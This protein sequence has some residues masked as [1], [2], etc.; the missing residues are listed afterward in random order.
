M[1]KPLRFPVPA[2][3]AIVILLGVACSSGGTTDQASEPPPQGS[4]A[5]LKS[6][7]TPLNLLFAQSELTTGKAILTFGLAN[8][9]GQFAT[10][11]T[12]G[13]WVAKDDR[14]PALGPFQSTFYDF[15]AGEKFPNEAPR[16]ELPGFFAA[17][18][19]IPEP[20]NWVVAAIAN[21]GSSRLVGMGTMKVVAEPAA[22]AIGTEAISAPTPVA[23]TDAERGKVCTRAPPD[24]MHL[25][26]LEEALRNGKPTVVTFSTP[27][28]CESRM[29]GPVVD[30]TLAVY[31]KVGAKKANFIHVEIYPEHD[32][33]KPA[34]AF[35]KWGF[36]SEPWTIVIDKDGVI[37][38]GFEGPLAAPLIEAELQPLL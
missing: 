9:Q 16:T 18:V 17:Q 4:I 26:S 13:V 6:G 31:E 32:Q 30:E 25:I 22:A 20:G 38:A 24:P 28:L 14:S 8:Q 5:A 19:D 7:G 10:G 29:C 37:K 27:A 21:T 1:S 12:P 33:S 36:Q 15:S 3:L 2:F 35:V 23:T 34:E 11:G